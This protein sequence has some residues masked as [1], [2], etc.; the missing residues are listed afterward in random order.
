ME[1]LIILTLN[2]LQQ[3]YIDFFFKLIDFLSSA[4]LV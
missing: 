2:A 1:G 3:L 4:R